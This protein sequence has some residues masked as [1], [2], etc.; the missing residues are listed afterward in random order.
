MNIQAQHPEASSSQAQVA[1][2]GAAEQNGPERPEE[3][4]K[5]KVLSLAIREMKRMPGVVSMF[6]SMSLTPKA[7]ILLKQAVAAIATQCGGAQAFFAN[8]NALQ[9]YTT[10]ATLLGQPLLVLTKPNK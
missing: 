8:N 4:E 3:A 6:N 7:R 10:E 2:P 5:N 9:D 1:R